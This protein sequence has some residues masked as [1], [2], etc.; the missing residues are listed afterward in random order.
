MPGELSSTPTS[1]SMSDKVTHQR[2]DAMPR[3]TV[4]PA[5]DRKFVCGE[6]MMLA[7]VFLK[8]GAV[9]PQHKHENEQITWILEGALRFWIGS[10]ES[11]VIDVRA[12][13]T[14]VIPSN[15]P[16]KAEA[17]EDTLDIDVFNPPRADWI[18]KT[19]AYFHQK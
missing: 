4:T 19:D 3:E 7:Q 8:Q 13:E 5:I 15:V 2:W 18:N 12:G 14:L 1:H 6:R 10:D 11:E 9:V 17:L 16:H